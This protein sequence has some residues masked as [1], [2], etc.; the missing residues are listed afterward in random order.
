MGKSI[1]ENRSKSRSFP[2]IVSMSGAH[3]TSLVRCAP[4]LFPQWIIDKT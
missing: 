2:I 3:L 4:F 1:F